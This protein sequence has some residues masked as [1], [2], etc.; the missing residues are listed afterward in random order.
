MELH[1]VYHAM[2]KRMNGEMFKM[3]KKYLIGFLMLCILVSSIYIMIPNSVRIDVKETHTTFMVWEKDAW[4]LS[5]TERVNLMSGTTKMRAKERSLSQSIDE[6]IITIR[7]FALYKDNISINETYIF[8][9]N[10]TDVRLFPVEHEIIV[11]NGQGKILQYEVTDLLYT[12]ETVK[13]ISSPQ[14]FGHNMKVEWDYGNYYSRIYKYKYQ[15]KGK[16]TVK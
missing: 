2:L 5:G 16:L 6:D 11:T 12:G 14:S 13:D 8:N 4:I 9:A 10:T 1:I 7:R 3:A 15:D